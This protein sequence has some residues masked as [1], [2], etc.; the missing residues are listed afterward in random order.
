[1][2]QQ[3]SHQ[4]MYGGA[5]YDLSQ[6]RRRTS[7]ETMPQVSRGGSIDDTS[8]F[9]QIP[10]QLDQSATANRTPPLDWYP[11]QYVQSTDDARKE[12]QKA[13]YSGFYDQWVKATLS[14]YK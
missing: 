2:Y 5:I 14:N 8:G 1:M 13:E 9:V 11:N 10:I 3:A 4:A 6:G 7:F 12:R